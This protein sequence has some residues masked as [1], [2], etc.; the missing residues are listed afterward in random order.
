MRA[1]MICLPLFWLGG[2]TGYAADLVVTFR[3]H[4]PEISGQTPVYIT[5]SVAGLGNW[6][7]GK[8]QMKY[9]GEQTW[10]HQLTI[11]QPRTIEYKY[12]LGS[13][14]REGA[15]ADGKPLANLV[16][17]VKQSAT[18]DD[19]IAH[20]TTKRS[21]IIDGQIT[22][23][24]RYHRQ[25]E[26]K[27]IRPRDVVVW[28]PAGY[29]ASDSRYPV[30][31]MHDGQNIVDPRTSAF[32]RDWEVD[33]TCTKLIASSEIEPLIVVGI[34]NTPD[35]SR[36]YMPGQQG[37]AYLSFVAGE[38]KPFI[39]RRY[40]TEPSR[41]HTFTAGSSA[42]GLCAFM[43]TWEHGSV[44][45]KAICMS[46]AFRYTREDGSVSVDYVTTVRESEP[47][48]D[49]VFWYV[50]NGGVGLEALLQP[51]IDDMLEVLR[52]KGLQPNRDYHWIHAPAARHTESA[53][54]KRFPSALKQIL[55][56][57]HAPGDANSQ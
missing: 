49:S 14:N 15:T 48:T 1:L 26:G 7:P 29:D 22:G 27:G 11:R 53:W 57:A 45:S 28:L 13:W 52:A 31:Y 39:D 33:E 43:L 8:V 5:G 21:R 12:T 16:F 55:G 9:E 30:L 25:M 17:H 54:A 4:A 10:T 37:A 3:L 35:R 51:G 41:E 18:H 46:P 44:F 24:V 19:R 50:D 20:W 56:V 32:G 23:Q 6:D 36:E 2:L 47:P 38:L 40:R 42:G 34:Y